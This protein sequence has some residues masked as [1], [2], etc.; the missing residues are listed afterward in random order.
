M[1]RSEKKEHERLRAQARAERELRRKAEEKGYTYEEYVRLKAQLLRDREQKGKQEKS[2][3]KVFARTFLIAFALLLVCSFG[4]TSVIGRLSE[5][6]IFDTGDDYTPILEEELKI[7][8]L[9]DPSNPLFDT[10]TTANRVNV[11]LL[12][13]NDGLTDTI[14]LT[15]FDMDSKKVDVISIPRDTFYERPGYTGAAQ[16]KINAA[17]QGNP[18]N[19][20]K[21]VSTLLQGMP[22]NYYAVIEYDGVKAI[23]DSMGGVPMEIPDINGKGGMYYNDPYDKP[24]LKIAIP[25][26]QQ[27]LDGEKAVQFLRFRKGYPEGDIGRIKAQQA[28]VK[29]AFKQCISKNL[30]SVAKTVF[31]N[32]DSDITLGKAVALATKAVGVNGEDMTTYMLPNTPDPEAPYYVYMKKE[33][34]LDMITQIY[35]GVDP[36]AVEE[37]KAMTEGAVTTGN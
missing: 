27:I 1:K 12:G 22:I 10:F 29:S 28:F 21:A 9:I 17:Y 23:V 36:N 2:T 11:L 26:G 31:Q 8:S 16:K 3:F 7:D 20:A 33:E 5:K 18:V 24:P 35:T 6:R 37:G 25:A 15:S 13:I 19:T 32:V 14:M 30:P 4:A 34:T